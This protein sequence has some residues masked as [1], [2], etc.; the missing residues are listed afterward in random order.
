MN[1]NNEPT[2]EDVLKPGNEMVAAGYCMYGSSCMLV[3]SSGTGVHGFTLDP[4]LGEFILTHPDIKIPTKGNIYSVNEG[5]AQNWDGPTTKYVERCKYPKDG[6][7]AKSLRYVGSVLYEVF[8]MAFLMEQAGGQ[9]FTGKKRALD[10]VPEKIHERSP[11]FLGS[12]D[13]VE[14]IKALYATEEKN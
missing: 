4:S 3:L 9:A 13:D 6:S 1:H 14:E 10:L 2:T 8:P 12:Y 5:N 7:P 11:I